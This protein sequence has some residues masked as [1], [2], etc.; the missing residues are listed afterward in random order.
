MDKRSGKTWISVLSIITVIG[1]WYLCTDVFH[2]VSKYALPSPISIIKAFVMKLYTK[3]PDGSTL[4]QHLWA[5]LQLV[6]TGYSLGLIVGVPLGICMAWFE[7]FDLFF[8]PLFDL[9]RPVPP[10]AWIPVII[11]LFGIGLFPKA[12]I[13]FLA[14]FTGFVI[15][16]YSGI[17][18]TKDI[19]IWTGKV[20]GASN[21]NL[22]FRVAIPT[23]LPMILT[24]M[25]VS[26]ATAWGSLVAAEMLASTRGLGYLIQQS[27]GIVRPDVILV[28]MISLGL[29][30]SV[31]SLLIGLLRRALLKGGR[32]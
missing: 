22:L 26:L 30:G 24:G 10:I 4:M 1:I 3:A 32:W 6:L 19:H 8:R 29:S 14:A 15:N 17:K 9:I 20:F 23:A 2:L 27:R 31:L 25:Q 21:L 7:T 13:V 16:S 18:N 5:S 12:L 28:G 11:V